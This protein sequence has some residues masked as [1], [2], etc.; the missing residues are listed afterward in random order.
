MLPLLRKKFEVQE[1]LQQWRGLNM[2][3][4]ALFMYPVC[5]QLAQIRPG[6]L[7]SS[8]L[9]PAEVSTNVMTMLQ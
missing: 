5:Q 2:N 9:S 1:Y 7:P 4:F 6:H 3:L 8:H